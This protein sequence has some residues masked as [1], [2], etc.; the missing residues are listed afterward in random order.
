MICLSSDLHFKLFICLYFRIKTLLSLLGSH[1]LSIKLA[2]SVH[3]ACCYPLC[4]FNAQSFLTVGQKDLLI[5]SNDLRE[6]KL[7]QLSNL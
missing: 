4:Y 2:Y 6:G 5:F 1:I 3:S 7:R